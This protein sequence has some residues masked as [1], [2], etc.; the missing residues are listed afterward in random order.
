MKKG[1]D[2]IGVA[3]CYFCHDGAGNL[4]VSKRSETT[5][6]EQGRWDC[7]GG[8]VEWDENIEDALV[9][10]IKEEYMTDVVK[11][12]FLGYRD[13]HRELDD[14][15]KTHWVMID[16]KVQVNPDQVGIGEPES[17]DELRW[18]NPGAI[19]EP[20]HSQLPAF[21]NKYKDKLV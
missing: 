6:D 9:R 8:S 14:G 5:R 20:T 10:E 21:L 13:V 2:C 15:T 17:I 18:V 11:A 7:G 19:P 12:E 16:Y 3:V 1:I 4:L